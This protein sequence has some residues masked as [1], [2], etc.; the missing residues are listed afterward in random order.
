MTKKNIRNNP[1]EKLFAGP[2]K[3]LFEKSYEE[4]LQ[5]EKNK[6][7]ECLGMTFENDEKRREYFLEKLRE[8][9]KDPE[10]RKIEGFPIGE[11]EDILALSDPPY[12]TA[13]PNPF[14]EDFVKHYGKPYDPT[15]NDYRREPFAA[16]VSEGRYSPETLCHSYH[17]KVPARAILRYILHY[18]SPG[19]V[20]LDGFCGTGMT[21]V[22]CM[23]AECANRDLR[24]QIEDDVLDSKWGLRYAVLVD[25]APAATCI[26]NA[27]NDP[28]NAEA[29]RLTA[30]EAID[31]AISPIR[32]MFQTSQGQNIFYSIWSDVFLCP[33]CGE[34]INYYLSAVSPDSKSMQTLFTCKHCGVEIGK[35]SMDRAMETYHD[36]VA[37]KPLRLAKC[38]PVKINHAVINRRQ[39]RGINSDDTSL[40]E[41]IRTWVKKYPLREKSI[42]KGDRYFK[43]GLHLI[44]V[45]YYHQMYPWRNAIALH[46][47]VEEIKQKNLPPSYYMLLTSTALKL[48]WMARYM[49]DAAGRIQN[50]I[51]YIPS[52]RQEMA[53]PLLMSKS[54]GYI[55]RYREVIS[56]QRSS[57]I[58]TESCTSLAS[59]PDNSIDYIFTDPPFGHNIQ[60]SELNAVWEYWLRI[61][62]NS[63]KDAVINKFQRKGLLEYHELMRLSFKSYF[64]TL[65]PGRWI[66]VEF[67]NSR[68]SVWNAIQ[69]ALQNVGFVI[70]DVR[71]L[72]KK[73]GAFNQVVAAGAVKQDLVI[74][75]YKPNEGL[76]DRFNLE[77][78]TE[79]GVW[80]FVRTH[81]KQLPVFVSKNGQAEVIAERQN[82]LLFDRMVAFHVQRGVT[83]HLSAAEFY[84]GLE[85]RFPPRDG[86]YFL[87]DQAAEYDKKRMTVKEVLQLKLFV[88]DEASAIQWLKQQLTKKPQTFQDIH[89]QFLKEIGGWQKHEK[90]LELSELLKENFLSY[91]G[92][93]DVPSQVHSYLSSNFKE[94]R[95]LEKDD[96]VL[97]AKAK[98]RWYVPDPNKAG[99]LE[100]LR[101]RAL[102]REFEEYRESKQKRLKVF[103]L[104]AVRAGFKKAWQERDYATIIAVARKIP[105]NILQEDPKLLMWYDQ[106]LT[107]TGDES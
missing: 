84:A 89:P 92:K 54:I 77:A 31:H 18:T 59:V 61:D 72:D 42:L 46:R 62:S 7:V 16:D 40:L 10:F 95:K 75:A 66:T 34:E 24:K 99:D 87:P 83:V 8:K 107:R 17:T 88:S 38:E 96:T 81:L 106:A 28:V 48:S 50:G 14:I 13:C 1:S 35:R 73:Q 93:G 27:Y 97:K 101:E 22:A 20:I 41:R 6:P 90:P 21:G 33:N 36:P 86:M 44:G 105:E 51:L 57:A 2:Q 25:L 103:R 91:D 56:A 4:R 19:D 67:H 23:L 85:Q 12:Y 79:E 52:L 9:L 78:G 74:S 26:A 98:D 100:K 102:M 60:Y 37:D 11:D 68:N 94:L 71:A 29:F 58:A 65:K 39:T 3:N 55:T 104:E 69:D 32:W 70:A 45:E 64:R 63:K 15:T 82:Y 47:L 80:D 49:F 5:E 53:A 43:D 76:E 30:K